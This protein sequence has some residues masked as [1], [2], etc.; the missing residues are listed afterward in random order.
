M[1]WLRKASFERTRPPPTNVMHLTPGYLRISTYAQPQIWVTGHVYDRHSGRPSALLRAFWKC[2]DWLMSNGLQQVPLIPGSRYASALRR[3]ARSMRFEP[4][5]EREYHHFYLTERRSHVRSFNVIMLI[6]TT[7]AGAY[8]MVARVQVDQLQIV[9]LAVIAL[10]YVSMVWAAYSRNYERRY[11]RVATYASLVVSAAGATYIGRAV[12]LAAGELMGLLTAYSIGL[13]FLAGIL[14]R[15]A[16][17]ANVFMVASFC[18]TL[19]LGGE[20]PTRVMELT[21]MLAATAAIGGIAFRHQGIRFR[22]SFLERG[23]IGEMAER[24]GLTGLKNRRAFDEHL[25]RVWQQ[26]LRDR[27]PLVLILSDV[28]HFKKF[29]DRYGHQA[30]DEALQRIAAAHDA[31][32]KRPLDIAARYGGEELAVLLFDVTREHAELLAERIRGAVLQL[33]IPH[34]DSEGGVVTISVGVAIVHPTLQHSPAGVVQLADE[35]LYGAKRSGNN[36]VQVFETEYQ[37][38]STGS[39]RAARAV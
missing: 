1:R 36:C 4:E 32:A 2:Y 12:H 3:G 22:R 31:F 19:A 5:L 11:L 25:T 37:D 24:D 21:T 9:S 27:R 33:Q 26:A 30:G 39:F 13:Y 29:N 20:S 14:Y 15:A 8:S 35:A 16:V 23:L 17:S 10:G 38:L 34:A 18:L 7:L 28:D 6:L